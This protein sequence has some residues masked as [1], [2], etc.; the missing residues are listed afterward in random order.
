M[1]VLIREC[2]SCGVEFTG[3][4]RAYYCPECR[5]LRTKQT[6]REYNERKKAG[7]VREIGSTDICENCGKSYTVTAGLQ[8]YCPDCKEEMDQE[9]SRT[10][11]LDHYNRNKD[12]INP[13]R[14]IRRAVP[15]R[16]C[17][18]CGRDFKARSSK[19][20]CSEECAKDA[21]RYLSRNIYEKR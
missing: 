19:N 20:Y 18:I 10:A 4:P 7:N 14:N 5:V 15:P 9:R 6:N 11:S 21:I 16:R 2:I 13:I 8:K 17:A 1:P 3:G 12:V